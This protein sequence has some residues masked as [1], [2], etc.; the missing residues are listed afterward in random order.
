VLSRRCDVEL[1][2]GIEP[3]SPGTQPDALPLSYTSVLVAGPG[4]DP[5]C[6]ALWAPTVRQRTPA[7]WQPLPE[8]NRAQ[9]SQSPSPCRSAKGQ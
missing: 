8:S 7:V 2:A 4:D 6:W 3:A 1:A 5:G 9:R